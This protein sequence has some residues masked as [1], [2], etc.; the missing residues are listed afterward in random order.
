MRIFRF[1]L[2]R[3]ACLLGVGTF[4]SLFTDSF[5][6]LHAQS[7]GLVASPASS[8]VVTGTIAGTV[9][10]PQGA[11]VP[12]AAITVTRVGGEPVAATADALGRYA[13]TGLAPGLYSIGAQAAEPELGRHHRC[14][15]YRVV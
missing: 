9:T 4:C 11:V 14:H 13:A 6:V 3:L 1:S 12:Q 10:D 15:H 2:L 8:G 7:S 5:A